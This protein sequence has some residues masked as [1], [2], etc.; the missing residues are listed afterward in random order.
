VI[1][2]TPPASTLA[3]KLFSFQPRA[4]DADGDKLRFA[5][6]NVPA[7]TSFDMRTGRLYGTPP[8]TAAGTS[9]KNI[10]IAVTDGKVWTVLPPFNLSVV[11]AI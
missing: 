10:Y 6:W 8:A 2:G 5:A 3:T 7:W 11:G 4:S 1:S 9:Y